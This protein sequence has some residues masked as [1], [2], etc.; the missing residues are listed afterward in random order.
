MS[1][2]FISLCAVTIK[3]KKVHKLE[4]SYI[5]VDSV[6]FLSAKCCLTDLSFNLLLL[7][8]LS[9][10]NFARFFPINFLNCSEYSPP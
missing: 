5:S 2:V 10:N 4:D 9:A 6:I 8:L 1:N 3:I 7:F